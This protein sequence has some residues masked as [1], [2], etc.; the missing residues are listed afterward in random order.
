MM[1]EVE[2][3]T[4]PPVV[5]HNCVN[6]TTVSTAT[7]TAGNSEPSMI[8]LPDETSLSDDVLDAISSIPNALLSSLVSTSSATLSLSSELHLDGDTD[9]DDDDDVHACDYTTNSDTSGWASMGDSTA[10]P[11]GGSD[12]VNTT[13]Y[14]YASS[15]VMIRHGTISP[16]SS[17]I[18]HQVSQIC[19]DPTMTTSQPTTI[20]KRKK[21]QGKAKQTV[22]FQIES[23]EVKTAQHTIPP[24]PPTLQAAAIKP[25]TLI[26]AP[27]SSRHHC[28]M[29]RPL[30]VTARRADELCQT[31]GGHFQ[32][33]IQSGMELIVP[34]P[35]EEQITLEPLSIQSLSS[36]SS[37]TLLNVRLSTDFRCGTYGS[38]YDIALRSGSND[39]VV[40]D[41]RKGHNNP[42]SIN[43]ADQIKKKSSDRKG[44]TGTRIIRTTTTTTRIVKPEV[45]SSE[46]I[47]T[48]TMTKDIHKPSGSEITKKSASSH[49]PVRPC[50][51]VYNN[52]AWPLSGIITKENSCG[53]SWMPEPRRTQQ[54]KNQLYVGTT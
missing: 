9:D 52:T 41:R 4:G 29:N 18:I 32:I 51:P 39:I 42:R 49:V 35:C 5:N 43:T 10:G 17:P 31:N 3:N 36:S 13:N 1:K 21:V 6:S 20:P 24:K 23:I 16:I 53:P 44:R 37:P 7:T 12:S 48:M 11:L 14:L 30:F 46:P 47:G 54:R 19:N 2:Q 45:S 33:A 8:H 25:P 28:Y 34:P 50:P 22:T 26:M 27:P 15:P 38:L 40:P